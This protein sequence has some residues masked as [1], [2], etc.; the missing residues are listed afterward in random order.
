[1]A[2]FDLYRN[3]RENVSVFPYLLDVTHEI[4]TISKLRVVVPLCNDSYNIAHLNPI[5]EIDGEKLYMSTM[6]IAGIPAT[7][8]G[9]A[10]DNLENRRTEIVDALDFLVNGF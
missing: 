6:D 7:M 3:S 1:M 8:L 10:I 2:Q 9:D 4:N 5:F